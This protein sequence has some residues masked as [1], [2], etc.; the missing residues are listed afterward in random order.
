M[1]EDEIHYLNNYGACRAEKCRCAADG[2]WRGIL[3]ENWE[4]LG[5]RSQEDLMKMARERI[6]RDVC[7]NE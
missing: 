5:A 1:D 4:S 7:G 2:I 6:S 3:C